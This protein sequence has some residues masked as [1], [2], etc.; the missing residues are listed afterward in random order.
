MCQADS[1][2]DGTGDTAQCRDC[3]TGS[4]TTD[5]GATELTQCCK[6]PTKKHSILST[7]FF[8]VGSVIYI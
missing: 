8:I 4:E 6:S 2:L 1:Y 3:P 7:L 5:T